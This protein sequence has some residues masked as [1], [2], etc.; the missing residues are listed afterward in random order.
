MDTNAF[1]EAQRTACLKALA[2]HYALHTVQECWDELGRGNPGDR[3]YV[4]VDREWLAP[5][6]TLHAPTK[7]QQAQARL[8]AA[9]FGELDAGERDLLAW[10]AALNSTAFFLTTGDRA[11]VAA[12]CELGL[13]DRLRS[14][15]E[16]AFAAGLKPALARHFTK[17]WLA[18][19]RT[20]FLFDSL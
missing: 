18:D 4:A 20:N 3:L 15:E 8:R 13:K 12:A 9:R 5:A 6:V 11:A 10:C 7:A 14:L 19:I 16:L 17:G 2:G 1:I